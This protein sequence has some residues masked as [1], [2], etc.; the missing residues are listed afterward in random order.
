MVIEWNEVPAAMLLKLVRLEALLGKTRSAPAVGA[1][2][3]TQFFPSIQLLVVPPPSQV[4]GTARSSRSRSSRQARRRVARLAARLAAECPRNQRWNHVDDMSGFPFFP[5]SPCDKVNELSP[6]RKASAWGSP[7]AGED[8]AWRRELTGRT[9]FRNRLATH[10]FF[11][12]SSFW[13]HSV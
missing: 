8:F 6:A 9:S 2:S 5:E 10:Y 4:D 3:P 11:C 7:V 12:S 13:R 1:R